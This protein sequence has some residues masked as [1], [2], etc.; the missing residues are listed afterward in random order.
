MLPGLSGLHGLSSLRNAGHK[1]ANNNEEDGG[2]AH[3]N[4]EDIAWVSKRLQAHRFVV[5]N[6]ANLRDESCHHS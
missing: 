2:K 6:Y 1:R 4:G 3:A 5:K